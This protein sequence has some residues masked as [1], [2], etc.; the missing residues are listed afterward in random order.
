MN[1]KWKEV[2]DTV[3]GCAYKSIRTIFDVSCV[4]LS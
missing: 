3:P 1:C 4:N 2:Q